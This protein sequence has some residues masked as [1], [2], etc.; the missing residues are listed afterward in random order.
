V[1]DARDVVIVGGG[2]NALITA[3]YLAQKGLKPLVLE[4]RAMVGGAAV[5]EEF[6]PG[7]RCSTLAHAAGP[8][9]KGVA[10]DMHL[11]R[12][13]LQ[14]IEP[15]VRVFAPSPDG[16]AL[17]LHSDP[18]SSVR[19]TGNFSDRDAKGYAELCKALKSAAPIVLSLLEVTPPVIENPA[20]DDL[21][22]LVKIGR[23]FRGLGKQEMMRVLRWGPM[24]VADFAAEFFEADL[25]RATVAAR[26]IFGAAM[27]PWSA[28]STALLLLRAAADPHPAG[29]S[30]FPRGGM[31]A[32]TSAMADAAKQAGAEIRTS[33]PVD[34]IN[35]KDG[36]VSGVALASGEEIAAETVIS[37]ADPRRT[38]LALL[39]PV[40]LPPSFVVKMRN[41]RSLGTMA[42]VNLALDALPSF[43]G[44]EQSPDGISALSGRIH[45]GPG[46]DYLER[47]FDA[48]KY[49]EFS[50]APYL[51]VTIPSISDLSLAPAG[52]H[53][54]SICMQFAPYHLKDGDWARHRDALRDTVIKTLAEYAPDLPSKILAVQTITPANLEAAYGLTGGHPFHGELALDQLFT[55]RPQLGWAR[56]RAPVHGLYLCGNG[57]HPG[58]GVTG[59]SGANAAREI[60]KD[61]R[62]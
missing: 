19:R 58:N 10:H 1:A 54:M 39:D 8:L 24:A 7:F 43:T 45:I 47:A 38:F 20:H 12:H 25:L 49:G 37:G 56:Y 33:A 11:D 27:G 35:V 57:T 31:G 9:L 14:M 16:R 44:V 15:D 53:V 6:H 17:I 22:K 62:R 23:K 13:G 34:R 41:Y 51:D 26:G 36:A 60:L 46:I 52:K 40:H 55:M 3:F 21:W 48:S 2:H 30:A 29:S 28:G 4:G 50:A 42:K 18:A 59:G 32:L 5:T 61:L